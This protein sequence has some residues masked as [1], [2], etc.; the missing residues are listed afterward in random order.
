MAVNLTLIDDRSITESFRHKHRK[1]RFSPMGN[2]VN[3]ITGGQKTFISF[4]STVKRDKNARFTFPKFHVTCF[5]LL[6][7]GMQLISEIVTLLRMNY[8]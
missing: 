6:T 4:N 7:H 2:A 1:T 5:A 8:L 3:S